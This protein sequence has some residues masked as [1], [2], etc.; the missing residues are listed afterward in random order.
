[1]SVPS[2]DTSSLHGIMEIGNTRRLQTLAV[3][4]DNCAQDDRKE[5]GS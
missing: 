1:V 4:A 2:L 3:R 5:L